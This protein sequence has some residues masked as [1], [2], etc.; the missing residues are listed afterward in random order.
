MILTFLKYVVVLSV[1][2]WICFREGRRY[3][4]GED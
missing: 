3:E 1:V 2:G 4:R